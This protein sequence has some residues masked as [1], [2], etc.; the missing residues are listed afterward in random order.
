MVGQQPLWGQDLWQDLWASGQTKTVILYHVTCHLPLASPGNDEADTMV[1]VCWL[2]GKP[3][4][5]VA[6]W[7]HQRLLLHVGQK[8]LWAVAH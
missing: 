5:D 1:Q 7:L 6:Q 3:V 4:S 2:D 8:T